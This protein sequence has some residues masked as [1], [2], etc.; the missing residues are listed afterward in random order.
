MKF[1]Y[2]SLKEAFDEVRDDF[3][4]GSNTDKLAST[5]KILGKTVANFGVFLTEATVDGLKNLP[6]TTGKKAKK[7][8][9]DKSHLMNEDQIHTLQTCVE[10]GEEFREQRIKKERAEE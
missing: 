9:E 1:S 8:L 5:A 2:F 7:L 6:E 3:S 4:Y 10:K